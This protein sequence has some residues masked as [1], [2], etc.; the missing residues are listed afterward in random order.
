MVNGS[1]QDEWISIRD[2][3]VHPN[4]GVELLK[5]FFASVFLDPHPRQGLPPDGP[6]KMPLRKNK[7]IGAVVQYPKPWL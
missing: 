6:K 7:A 4:K 1:T 5:R 2:E 3:S